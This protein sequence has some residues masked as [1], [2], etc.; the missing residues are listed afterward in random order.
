[1]VFSPTGWALYLWDVP[2]H[3]ASGGITG[4]KKGTRIWSLV[5]GSELQECF[6]PGLTSP[7]SAKSQKYQAGVCTKTP[8]E[9][10]W[11]HKKGR[12]GAETRCWALDV[13]SSTALSPKDRHGARPASTPQKT[14]CAK[15]RTQ[16]RVAKMHQYSATSTDVQRSG[17]SHPLHGKSCEGQMTKVKLHKRSFETKSATKAVCV[18]ATGLVAPRTAFATVSGLRAELKAPARSGWAERPGV[19]VSVELKMIF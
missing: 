12:E 19:S 4:G 16:Y 3:P 18:V 6:S 14:S 1:M 13:V 9:L 11:D 17:R 8:L 2:F 10:G 15:P 5:R 7:L